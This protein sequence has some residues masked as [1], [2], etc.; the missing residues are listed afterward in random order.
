MSIWK[1]LLPGTLTWPT[2]L[3]HLPKNKF[4]PRNSYTYSKNQF[5]KGKKMLVC[6][7]HVTYAFQ[8]E[9]TLYSCLNVKLLLFERIDHL[10]HLPGPHIKEI[11]TQKISYAYPKI[12]FLKINFFFDICMK[13]PIFYPPKKFLILPEKINFS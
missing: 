3:A 5:S 1:N 2:H 11:I 10:T 9:S 13:E 4:V 6:S 7:Y 8:S 12:Q